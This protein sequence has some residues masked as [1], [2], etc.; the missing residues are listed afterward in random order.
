[1]LLLQSMRGCACSGEV[2]NEFA[3]GERGVAQSSY[4]VC[5]FLLALRRLAVASFAE[6]LRV[7]V[8]LHFRG[9]G[10]RGF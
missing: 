1:M 2:P 4:A 5:D 10:I 8:G 9:R 7:V 3:P 6:G